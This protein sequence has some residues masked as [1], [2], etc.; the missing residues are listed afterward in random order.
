MHLAYFIM[1]FNLNFFILNNHFAMDSE[2]APCSWIINSFL[3]LYKALTS[4]LALIS[5]LGLKY[6]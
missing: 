3:R 6:N 2:Y 4:F 5:D 1:E